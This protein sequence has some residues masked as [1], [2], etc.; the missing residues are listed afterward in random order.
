MFI[1]LEK[2]ASWV[3]G[4][5]RRQLELTYDLVASS[6]TCLFSSG[7]VIPRP[8]SRRRKPPPRYNLHERDRTAKTLADLNAFD[9][10]HMANK[11]GSGSEL[12]AANTLVLK[13]SPF[14]RCAAVSIKTPTIKVQQFCP[15]LQLGN[16][17]Q[18]C[19]D[20]TSFILIAN[21]GFHKRHDH[22]GG[23]AFRLSLLPR[24]RDLRTTSSS[25][26]SLPLVC[27]LLQEVRP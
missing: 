21:R 19:F 2:E 15:L 18:N 7:I 14:S 6:G 26:S 16:D 13:L 4:N 20:L 24:S 9:T 25:G 5:N 22:L 23:R 3:G 8:L 11:K 12:K 17:V 10:G 27:K 1:L